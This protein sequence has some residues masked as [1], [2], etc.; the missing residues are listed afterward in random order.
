MF[1]NIKIQKNRKK[2][3]VFTDI[4]NM[5]FRYLK[6]RSQPGAEFETGFKAKADNYLRHP[7]LRSALKLDINFATVMCCALDN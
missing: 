7:I 3:T 5:E 1:M 4:H 2:R 6:N